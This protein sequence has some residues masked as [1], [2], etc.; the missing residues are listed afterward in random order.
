METIEIYEIKT[1]NVIETKEFSNE[2]YL[3]SFMYYF[4]LQC[5]TKEYNWRYT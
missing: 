5:N 3:R 4:K 1:N 2:I